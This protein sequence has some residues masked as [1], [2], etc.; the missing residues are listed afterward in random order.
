M[1][2]HNPL[3]FPPPPKEFISS[4]KKYILNSNINSASQ[5]NQDYYSL[6][7]WRVRPPYKYP[8]NTFNTIYDQLSNKCGREC[9][10]LQHKQKR[11]CLAKC[12]INA[13]KSSLLSKEKFGILRGNF[14]YPHDHPRSLDNDY[15]HCFHL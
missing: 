10:S 2:Y 3:I 9:H 12:A 5:Q 7:G 6:Y 4:A 14:N 8:Q 15:S 13:A 1:E 11:N